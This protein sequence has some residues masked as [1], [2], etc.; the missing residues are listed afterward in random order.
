MSENEKTAREDLKWLAGQNM[1]ARDRG[2]NELQPEEAA[3]IVFWEGAAAWP[4]W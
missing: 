1:D 4:E 2:G 3:E